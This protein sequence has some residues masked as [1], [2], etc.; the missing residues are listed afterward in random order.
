MSMFPSDPGDLTGLSVLGQSVAVVASNVPPTG[1]Y[2]LSTRFER[3]PGTSTEFDY[4][5]F[6]TQAKIRNYTAIDKDWMLSGTNAAFAN[7]GFHTRGGVTIAT[8][9]ATNDQCIISPLVV[10]S[11]EQA[12]WG[13]V[14]WSPE[15]LPRMDLVFRTGSSVA[16]IRFLLGFKLTAVEE[17][18]DTTVTITDD[19]YALF[20]FDTTHA[21][22][23]TSIHACT[24]NAGTDENSSPPSTLI[25]AV[26][27]A[28]TRYHLTLD[29][30]TDRRPH[31]SIN[32]RKFAV[33]AAMRT[34]LA[35]RP[36]F[37]WRA[38]AAAAKSLTLQK[39]DLSQN[40]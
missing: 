15:Y 5:A 32:G 4:S 37:A 20:V 36:V 8:A 19:D 33:G 26:M 18:H 22:S 31:Y 39:L 16:D 40:L 25:D 23:A 35:L 24:G 11:V 34:G 12:A 10:N 13:G 1:R 6:D 14:Q 29:F 9:G 2:A 17:D 21:A 28:S 27:Q 7:A 38:L 3:R 30:D